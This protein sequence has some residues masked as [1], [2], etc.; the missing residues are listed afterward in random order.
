MSLGGMVALQWVHEFADEVAGCVLINTSLRGHSP[1]WERLHPRSYLR[2]C[3][4][5]LPGLS[6]VER[7]REILAMTSG[8]PQRHAGVPAQ[9]AA[10]A[11]KRP[12]SRS[13]TLRQLIA[14]SR[15]TPSRS[16]PLAPVLVLAS[17]GDRLVSPR[18]SQRLASQWELPLRVNPDA[19]HDIPL[20][21][22]DW[23]VKQI[24]DWWRDRSGG[25]EAGA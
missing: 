5:L 8:N 9:W 7:E 2:L 3:R 21:D 14:A 19:G 22:P 20:D 18:C 13:N 24:A 12:V 16:R 23:V 25:G 10:I 1:F 4:L 15:Y 17:R 11:K 6:A